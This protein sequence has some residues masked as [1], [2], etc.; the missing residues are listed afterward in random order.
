MVKSAASPERPAKYYTT[1]HRKKSRG[2][3]HKKQK[4]LI[5]RFVENDEVKNEKKACNFA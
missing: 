2:K 5:S 4:K 1:P 3:L